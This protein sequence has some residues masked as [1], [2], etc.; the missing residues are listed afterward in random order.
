MS[1]R[2][3]STTPIDGRAGPS[4]AGRKPITWPHVM[5]AK[6]GDTVTLFDGCGAEFTARVERINRA[7]V[8]L[9]VLS[10]SRDRPRVA[11]PLAPGRGPAQGRPAE[12]A[13]RKGRRVRHD[14]PAPLRTERGVAQPSEEATE[15][16]LRAV[17]EASKQCGR[18]RLMRIAAPLAWKAFLDEPP[19]DS[20]R[21]VAHPGEARLPHNSTAPVY[22]AVGPEGGLSDAEVYLAKESGWDAVSLG[23]KESCG[24]RLPRYISPRWYRRRNDKGQ[25]SND[26]RLFELCPFVILLSFTLWNLSFPAPALEPSHTRHKLPVLT[27]FGHSELIPWWQKDFRQFWDFSGSAVLPRTRM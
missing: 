23:A 19:T 10:G 2:Y 24:W 16:L 6:A 5:R 21:L 7:T 26:K 11:Q 17:I 25:R 14:E 1:Q 20:L 4:L 15:R 13:D 27:L 3:Y 18:N 9:A 22:L 8:E 12:V